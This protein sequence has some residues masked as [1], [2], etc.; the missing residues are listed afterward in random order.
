METNSCK[1]C[2]AQTNGNFCSHCGHPVTLKK[3][4]RDY[5]FYE[6][7]GALFADRG[8][9]Y[10]TKRMIVSPGDSVRH[11]ITED[12]S[13]FVKPVTY[14]II[15]SLIYT[16][17]SHFFKIDF[18]AQFEMP[19]TPTSYF[20]TTWMVENMGYSSILIGLYMAFWIKLLFRKSDFNLFE[21]FILV[22][23]VS[24][25][26][27]LLISVAFILLAL[28]HVDFMLI[29]VYVSMVY[30]FWAI[31]QFFDKKKAKSYLKVILAHILGIFSISFLFMIGGIVEFLVRHQM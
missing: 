30:S 10:T 5:V 31:G 17:V 23:Y 20:I 21:I 12:R 11:Y 2:T 25:M 27:T 4:D 22:C 7:K 19:E 8:F 9:L 3:I 28:L 29:T 26:H 15:T 18:L 16:L 24:G 14:L 1:N 13:R 6:I